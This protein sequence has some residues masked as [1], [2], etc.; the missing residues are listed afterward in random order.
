MILDKAEIDIN[1]YINNNFSK[2]QLNIINNEL[3]NL[4]TNVINNKKKQ[5]R[6]TVNSFKWS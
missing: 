6:I 4:I 1:D 2:N 5:N 3:D